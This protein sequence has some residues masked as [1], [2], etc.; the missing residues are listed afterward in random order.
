MKQSISFRVHRETASAGR[1][2]QKRRTR[3]ALLDAALQLSESGDSPTLESVAEKALISRATAYRYFPS[4]EAL[5][6]E[7]HFERVIAYTEQTVMLGGDPIEDMGRAVE[8]VHRS[9]LEDE[10]GIHVIE[11]S[12]MQAWLDDTPDGRR[13][14]A[15]LRMKIIDQILAKL[16]GQLDKA[17][18]ARL[19]VALT[20]V[21]GLEAVLS[22][23]DVA[24]ASIDEAAKTGSWAARAL[25]TQAL[26]EASQQFPARRRK[27]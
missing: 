17:A 27:R 3:Q 2:N 13:P 15:L 16:P 12:F 9:L 18:H 24:G 14:R 1:A 25:V 7:A 19:R 21:I 22:M 26:A 11:R 10:V 6:H 4:V 8:A 23:R 20:L 5:M